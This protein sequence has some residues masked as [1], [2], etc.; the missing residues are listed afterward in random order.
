MDFAEMWC[1]RALQLHA[2]RLHATRTTG[3]ISSGLKLH[4]ITICTF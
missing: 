4:C 3:V 1:V 2:R